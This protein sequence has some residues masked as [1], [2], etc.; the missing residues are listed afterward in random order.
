MLKHERISG[1]SLPITAVGTKL[2][3]TSYTVNYLLTQTLSILES[4]L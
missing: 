4:S 3:Y 2:A 1:T